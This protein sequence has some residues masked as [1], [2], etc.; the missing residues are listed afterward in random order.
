ME[1]E[2]VAEM[3]KKKILEIENSKYDKDPNQRIVT[4]HIS[5]DIFLQMA[6]LFI[7]MNG[8]WPYT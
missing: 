8:R 1:K 2:Q 7:G 6:Y 4:V 3:L 5:A